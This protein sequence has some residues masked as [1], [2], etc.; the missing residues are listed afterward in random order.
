VAYGPGLADPAAVAVE[1]ARDWQQE[2]E[3]ME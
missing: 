1:V 2:R 3:R